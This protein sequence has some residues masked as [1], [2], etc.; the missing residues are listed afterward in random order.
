MMNATDYTET[1]TVDQTPAEVFTAINNVRGWWND[2][3]K[4]G[5]QKLNDEFETRFGDVH[6]SKQKLIEVVPD[7]KVVWL[8][9]ESELNFLK[10]KAEWTGTKVS[11]EIFRKENKTHLQFKHAG[12]RPKI[13]CYDACST[14]WGQYLRFSLFYLITTGKGQPGFPPVGPPGK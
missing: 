6:Y 13:E 10:D 1:L 4:G 14:A 2:T 9:T 12:L 5:F 8:V 7:K 3:A 11:F